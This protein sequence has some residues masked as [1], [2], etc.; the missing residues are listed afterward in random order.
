[1]LQPQPS[2]VQLPPAFSS[3]PKVEYVKKVL[4]GATGTL[5]TILV[6]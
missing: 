2:L 1:M 5:Y 4:A 6:F 3:S